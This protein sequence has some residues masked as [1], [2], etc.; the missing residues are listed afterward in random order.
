MEKKVLS[1]IRER[2]MIPQGSSGILAVSGGADSVCLL[3]VM[4]RLSDELRLRL[5][6]CHVIHGIRGEE[7]EEDAA[8]VSDEAKRL[9]L[10]CRIFRRNVP[11]L[12]EEQRLSP[13]EAG[14]L[15]RYDCLEKL[16]AE[17]SADW[18]AVAHQNDDQAETILFHI[19][20]GTGLR[21]L[22]GIEPVQ[23]D[24]VRP[25][26][27][28]SR[29]EIEAWLRAE[30]LRW[31]T[32]STNLESEYAR[33][34]LRNVVFPELCR[35]NA[36]AKVHFL[37]LA[38]EAEELY[39]IQEAGVER[40]RRRCLYR[41]ADGTVCP[42][43]EK[44]IG[45]RTMEVEIPD[46]ATLSES[47]AVL[48]EFVMQELACLAGQRKDIT[49][50]HIDAVTALFEKETG[51]QVD[52]P[53]GLEAVRS[54]TGVCLRTGQRNQESVSCDQSTEEG[55]ALGSGVGNTGKKLVVARHVYRVGEDI[56][57]GEDRKLID[58]AAVKGTPVLRTPRPG[59][60]IVIDASGGSKAL[61]R[62][63]TDQKIPR[64][65]RT[66]WP[67]VA[68]DEKIL[69]VVGLRL[70]ACCKVTEKTGEVYLLRIED[71]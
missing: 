30:G 55:D 6:V 33:N 5:T 41:M 1:Y 48:G 44:G 38:K 20:R 32:D 28:V 46:A 52:L 56:P 67:V 69:W 22:R 8:F 53:Y 15:A 66:K 51:K 25:L 39:D 57:A 26:L 42:P 16:K 61:N 29:E 60:R 59:D 49:R 71:L 3:H 13:E 11:A 12:A 62:F 54:Y 31:R 50:K 70:S 58:A 64:E 40:L 47:K 24:R 9:G 19:L 45:Q 17:L 68:D 21:G 10:E 65:E 27:C 14:R 34:R 18:I 37:L 36:G 63:F 35:I 7:A 4:H 2:N 43:Q 23:G